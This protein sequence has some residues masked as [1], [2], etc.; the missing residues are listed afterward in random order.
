MISE[1]LI[2]QLGCQTSQTQ[3]F[4]PRLFETFRPDESIPPKRTF[5]LPREK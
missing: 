2:K 4:S 5:N 1:I 3:R